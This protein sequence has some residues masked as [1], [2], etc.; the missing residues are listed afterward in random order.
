MRLFKGSA[1][2]ISTWATLAVAGAQTT[3]QPI[4]DGDLLTLG[5]NTRS[6]ATSANDR[7]AVDP[8]MPLGHL[9]LQ[10]RRS[11]EQEREV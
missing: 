2:L 4:D 9:E 1:I 6:E 7:G 10:L 3:V 5:G 11:P 8:A